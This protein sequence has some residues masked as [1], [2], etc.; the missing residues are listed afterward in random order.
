MKRIYLFSSHL[1]HVCSH[2]TI[3]YRH[4]SPTYS[5]LAV[6]ARIHTPGILAAVS[7]SFDQFEQFMIM[8]SYAHTSL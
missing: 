6:S 3:I 8:D 4:K 1:S 2:V 5:M 7:S